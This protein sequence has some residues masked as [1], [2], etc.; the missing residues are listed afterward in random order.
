MKGEHTMLL[1]CF[2]PGLTTGYATFQVV[3]ASIVL[4]N[5]GLCTDEFVYKNSFDDECI[6]D[7]IVVERFV[8]PFAT[9]T[10]EALATIELVG[11]LKAKYH[12][13]SEI[14]MQTQAQKKGYLQFAKNMLSENTSFEWNDIKKDNSQK[15]HAI[16][17][18]AHGIRYCNKILKISIDEIGVQIDEL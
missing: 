18:I 16:D 4:L 17:A 11:A 9:L 5:A 15:R 13:V 7:T 14:A 12:W 1:K 10:K 6:I 3:N 2:D 8:N